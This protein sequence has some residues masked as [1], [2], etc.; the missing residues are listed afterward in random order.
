MIHFRDD[1]FHVFIGRLRT[2]H[3]Q[4]RARIRHQSGP[5]AVGI[6]LILTDIRHQT[7][8]EIPSEQ[9][10]Q[11]TQFQV[12]RMLAVERETTHAERTLQ[13]ILLLHVN[14]FAGILHDVPRAFH[15]LCRTISP[16]RL[17]PVT[18]DAAHHVGRYLTRHVHG[19]VARMIM[20]VIEIL[21][22]LHLNAFIILQ[23]SIASQRM[24]STEK[25]TVQ[26]FASQYVH[27]LVVHQKLL[28]VDVADN[29]EL[30]FRKHRLLHQS[31]HNLHGAVKVFRQCIQCHKSTVHRR[32]K[33]EPRPVIIQPFGNLARC[34]A[35]RSL[36]QHTVGKHG[37]KR[38]RL[39]ELS[40]PHQQVETNHVLVSSRKH[41]QRHTV[42]H[43]V[44][45]RLQ[46][47][48]MLQLT[49]G[50]RHTTV[51]LRHSASC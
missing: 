46:D 10:N 45:L 14:P 13:G 6:S 35:H 1:R 31:G 51:E 41:I 21:Q 3:Q 34:H 12:I 32:R 18:F 49:D 22:G 23:F 43:T 27:P 4:T 50:R 40:A 47:G 16:G 38:L 25:R 11:H 44:Q 42:L 28:A 33:V 30:L 17:S 8:A 39:V 20:A 26:L 5:D 24:R 15:L 37:L 7:T 48:E 36:T 9:R 19:T 2:H 29:A